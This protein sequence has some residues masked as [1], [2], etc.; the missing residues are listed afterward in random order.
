[1]EG[2]RPIDPDKRGRHKCLS[3]ALDAALDSML[4]ERNDFFDS[5]PARWRQLF[6][7]LAAWPGRYEDGKIVLYVSSASANFAVRPRLKAIQR[8][9][10]ELPGAPANVNL[11]LEIRSR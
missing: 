4:K 2:W 1:M 7:S 9:L 6:P 3:S 10:Q 8:R 5:L 11:R